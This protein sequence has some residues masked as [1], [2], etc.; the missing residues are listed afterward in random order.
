MQVDSSILLFLLLWSVGVLMIAGV[1]SAWI[2]RWSERGSV[3][4]GAVGAGVSCLVG[5]GAA[6]AALAGRAEGTLELPW[7]MPQGTFSIGL[8]PLSAFFLIPMFLLSGVAAAHAIGYFR[9]WGGRNPGRFWLF[10]NA[11]IASMALVLTA[12]NG[13]LFLVAWEAMSLASFFLV[14]F[15]DA[16]AGA[17][18][19]GWVYLVATHIGTAF[20]LAL[21]LLLGRGGGSQDFAQYAAPAGSAGL[22]FLL[23]L[24]GFGTKAGLFPLHVW[25]PEAHPAAPSPVSAVMSGVMIKTGIYGIVRTL[26]LL[27]AVPGWCAWV[28]LGVGAASGLL[29]ILFALAQQDLKRMLAYS[30]VENIGIIAMGIGL[31]ML[32]IEY[33]SPVV[34]A[35]GF[36]GGLL[37]VLNHAMFKGLLFLGAGAVVHA[38]GTRDLERLGGLLK[39]MPWTGAAFLAGAVAI[40]G[41]PPFNGFAGEFLIYAGSFRTILGSG[42]IALGGLIVVVALALI[43]GLAA[44]CFAKAFGIAFLGEPRSAAAAAAHEAGV[45]MR[46]PMIALAALCLAVGLFAGAVARG[47]APVVG[48]LAGGAWAAAGSAGGG[49]FPGAWTAM[50]LVLLALGVGLA[51]ARRRLL[52][53]RAVRET[54]TWDCGYA[55]PTAR[56]QYTATGFVQPL[57]RGAEHLLRPEV[58]CRRPEGIYPTAASFRAETPDLARRGL[59]DPAFRRVADALGHLR[60]LQQGRVHFYILYV[61]ITLMV[62]LAWALHP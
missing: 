32:G 46:G 5:L 62:L 56:M 26:V 25:L 44:A 49:V 2:G 21:F 52:A 6:L 12:R 24:I 11:L 30:S 47:L 10:Y 29:G 61:L 22:L 34:A 18:E 48:M 55:A 54:V 58:E 8:D 9:P 38:A 36:G 4:V 27:G 19:A 35:L 42:G 60:W 51:V 39:R 23:A 45:A 13:V 15:D 37:H 40:C 7:S 17:R 50:M 41:L 59:F 43:G 16:D 3:A 1:A 57:T 31:G 53:G 28:V 33:G 20:L 14:V